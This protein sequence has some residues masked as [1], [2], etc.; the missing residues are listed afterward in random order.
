MPPH[1]E[2]R[3]DFDRDSL[4]VY[5]AYDD[6][7]ADAALAAGRFVPPF[8]F[9]RMTWV[10]P[11]FLWLMARSGWGRKPGQ[12]RILAVRMRLGGWRS[13][14][15]EAVLTAY[16]PGVHGDPE[17]WAE[18]FAAAPVHV[19]WDPERSLRGQKLGWR[20]IQVG[21]S[22]HR[23]AAYAEQWVCGL[24]D[25]TPRVRK[26]REH[27]DAGRTDAARR[28]LPPERPWPAPEAVR[29]RLGMA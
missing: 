16:E 4:V 12:T 11:S 8:S 7:I 21:I 27:L 3:A 20:S 9:T 14:L 23:I 19:Q 5:Q 18:A 13:A 17:A 10:K 2:I 24:D 1:R 28:L 26:L 6:R 15:S 25:L 29:Q 22:R